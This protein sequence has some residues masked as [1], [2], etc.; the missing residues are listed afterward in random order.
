M[1]AEAPWKRVRGWIE[2]RW[3][4]AGGLWVSEVVGIVGT[5]GIGIEVGGGAGRDGAW[6]RGRFRGGEGASESGDEGACGGFAGRLGG[7]E[8]GGTTEVSSVSVI[9]VCVGYV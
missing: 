3:T 9:V 7:R 6:V 5:L 8:A 2:K 1:L 4:G